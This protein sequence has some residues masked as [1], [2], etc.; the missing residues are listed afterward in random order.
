MRLGLL[1]LAAVVL[2]TAAARADFTFTPGHYYAANAQSPVL[3]EYSQSGALLGTL[4]LP[5]SEARDLRGITFGPDGLLYASAIG[6][7]GPAVLALDASGAIRQ[8]YRL[9]AAALRDNIAT[10]KITFNGTTGYVTSPYTSARFQVGDPGSVTP[11]LSNL[12]VYDLDVLPGGD[13]VVAINRDVYELTAAGD[14]VRRVAMAETYVDVRS[15]AYDRPSG[16]LFVAHL[17]G[18]GFPYSLLRI[19]P[20]RNVLEDYE[21][22]PNATDLFI[23]DS[24]NLLVGN[25]GLAPRLYSQDLD[26]LT[27]FQGGPQIFVT[28]A[29]VPEPAAVAALALAASALLRRR[30]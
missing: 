10:G 20:V 6:D 2:G 14:Y 3:S 29:P 13:L 23:T 16:K 28:Q 5:S 27:E 18:T 17:T 15:V 25:R 22:F 12:D 1:S 9:P 24:G 8:K 7:A 26:L 11:I 30:R 4:I 21:P 19:D